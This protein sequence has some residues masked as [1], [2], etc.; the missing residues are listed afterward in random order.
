MVDISC[1]PS[2]PLARARRARGVGLCHAPVDE[3]ECRLGCGS[4][5]L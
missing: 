1:Y 5:P 3:L 2:C 4:K